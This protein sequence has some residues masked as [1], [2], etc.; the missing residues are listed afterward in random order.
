MD[1]HRKIQEL[2]KHS[3][4]KDYAS[5]LRVLLRRMDG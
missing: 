1:V 5:H 3:L 4:R 2:E